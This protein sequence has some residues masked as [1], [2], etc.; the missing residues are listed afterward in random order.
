VLR[1]DHA[2]LAAELPP[3]EKEVVFRYRSNYF[4]LGAAL[5]ALT[6]AG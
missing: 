3:G 5:S 4:A 6:F 1:A 2:F